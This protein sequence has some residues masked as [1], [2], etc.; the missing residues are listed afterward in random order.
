M[1]ASPWLRLLFNNKRFGQK[2]VALAFI[3]A[4]RRAEQAQTRAR[5]ELVRNDTRLHKMLAFAGGLD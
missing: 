5:L 3:Q 1:L 2:A 4:Q